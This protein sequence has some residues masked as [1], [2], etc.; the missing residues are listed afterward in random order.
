M[1]CPPHV[2][3]FTFCIWRGYKTK[4]DVCQ[5][6]CEDFFMLDVKHSSADVE[7]EFG[8]VSLFLI[9]TN[10]SFDKMTFSIF[11]ASRDRKR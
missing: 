9:C 2:F 8:V 10:F 3:I 7:T 6:L 4:C 5:F 1:P 11:Q